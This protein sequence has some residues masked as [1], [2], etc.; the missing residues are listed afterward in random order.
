MR[1]RF[2]LVLYH[3][4]HMTPRRKPRVADS[5]PREWFSPKEAGRILGISEWTVRARMEAG[6]LGHRKEGNRFLCTRADI[7]SYA[8][9]RREEAERELAAA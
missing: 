2:C 5:A 8:A 3:Y 7:D 1:V 6:E 9:R 4:Q